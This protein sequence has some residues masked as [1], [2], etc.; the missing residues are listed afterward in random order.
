MKKLQGYF[1]REEILRAIRDFFAVQK[2]HEV[3][4]P[5]LN[6]ALP[7]EPTVYS[8]STQW[9]KQ[10]GEKTLYLSTSPESGIKKMLATGLG[11]CYAIS[12]CF[13]N[14]ED[15]GPQ[16]NPEF[17]MLEW[18]RKNAQYQDIMRDVEQ[19]FIFIKKR[20][21][22]FLERKESNFLE[23]QHQ[24]IDVVTQWPILSLETLFKKYVGIHLAEIISDKAIRNFATTKGYQTAGATWEQLFDQVVLNEVAPHFP[25]L[26]FFL[27]DF[28]ARISPLCAVNA[29]KKYLAERFEFFIAG[30][31]IGN[32]NTE[33]TDSQTVKKYFQAELSERKKTMKSA[34]PIDQSFLDAIENLGITTYAGI[35]LGID[36][37]AMIFADT[38]N[39]SDVEFF[40]F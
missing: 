5:V 34:H 8:F 23:Y 27:T 31:E 24:K 38:Q 12:K 16:H 15:S 22:V 6:E 26:P 4:A 29:H 30:M 35:G 7:L 37:L 14:L 25:A 19:L 36:R 28:P 11:N 2:F 39:I 10:N 33:N 1:I 9:Q 21:D 3:I 20:V 17:L 18:Y 13:R 32:G 40:S